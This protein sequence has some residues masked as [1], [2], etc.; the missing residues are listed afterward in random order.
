MTHQPTIKKA[1]SV[2]LF[3]LVML[4]SG[5]VD[6]VANLPS[7]AIFGQQLIFFF[8]LA[9]IIFLLPI[10]LISAELCQQFP[11]SSGVYAWSKKAFG[12]GFAV[13]AIWL[14]WI[15]TM[16]WFPTCLTTL[17]GTIA[18]LVNPN[19]IHHPIFLVLT[20]LSVFWVMTFIN[21]K[22]IQQSTKIASWATTLGM[23]IPLRCLSSS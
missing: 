4:M 8:I 10:S 14:Q 23:M 5:A 1:V 21:M 11:N 7:I 6:G 17:V 20:S 22:G 9:S 15:N 16:V 19:L 3:G 13:L 18:Y 2:S 12:G